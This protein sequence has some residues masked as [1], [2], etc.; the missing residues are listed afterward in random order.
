MTLINRAVNR[1]SGAK[2]LHD[3]L[4]NFYSPN[5][6]FEAAEKLRQKVFEQL[7]KFAQ[8]SGKEHNMVEE[9]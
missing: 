3:K 9:I 7:E 5:V 8:I 6:D 2:K 4:E 1:I